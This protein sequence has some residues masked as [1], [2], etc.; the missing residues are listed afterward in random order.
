MGM[1]NHVGVVECKDSFYGQHE[2]EKKPVGYELLNKWDAWLKLGTLASEME[3]AALFVVA[4]SL[5]VR[6]GSCFLTVANQ[7]RA[8]AGLENT[9]VHDTDG[10]IRAAVSAIKLLIKADKA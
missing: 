1:T 3:S 9:Q 2:P 10:A 7:E 6:A 4:A 5:G 8:K